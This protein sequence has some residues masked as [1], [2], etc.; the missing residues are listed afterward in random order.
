[1]AEFLPLACMA[2]LSWLLT[3]ILVVHGHRKALL[4]IPNERSSHSSPTPTSGGIAI[5][6]T[7]LL[8][9][10]WHH[11]EQGGVDI[12]LVVLTAIGVTIGVLGYLDDRVEVPAR[13]RLLLHLVGAAILVSGMNKLPA[14]EIIGLELG[15]QTL[16]AAI[17]IFCLV[18]LINLFNFMDGIDGIA[19]VEVISVLIGASMIMWLNNQLGDTIWLVALTLSVAGFLVVN[20]A[21]AKIFMGDI[22]SGFL[23]VMLGGFA[24]ITAAKGAVSIWSWAILLAVFVA[25]ASVTLVRRAMRGEKFYQA[26]R[27]H[28]YQILARRMSSHSKVS[29]IVLAVNLIWL[30][31]LAYLVNSWHH[32]GFAIAVIAYLPLIVSMVKIGAGT[33]NN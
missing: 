24:L 5:L 9:L 17:Y 20:W 19:G 22:G 6:I 3:S 16:I 10:A 25:D 4:A 21:P 32:L 14:I 15:D 30:L 23:G 27:S 33:T 31:P 13:W 8:F 7:F 26:H 18:W 2:P 11:A 1:M 28:A 29:L 12:E